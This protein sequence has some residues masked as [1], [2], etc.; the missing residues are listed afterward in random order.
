MGDRVV[1]RRALPGE[2]RIVEEAVVVLERGLA[3][4][5]RVDP[6]EVGRVEVVLDRE[7][8]VPAHLEADLAVGGGRA[9]APLVPRP[10]QPREALR[11]RSDPGLEGRRLPGEVDEHEV[12][13][14]RAPHLP[15]PVRGAVEALRLVHP[16]AAEVRG[17]DETPPKVVGP[18]VVG[19]PD[20]PRPPS[21]LPDQLGAAMRAHVVEHAHRP[22]RRADHEERQA[23]EPG[24]AEVARPRDVR[25]VSEAGPR[26]GEDAF[27]LDPEE[28]E[29]RI[30]AV[31]EPGRLPDGP[32]D[33]GREGR[34][35][36]V[37]AHRRL[38]DEPTGRR[39]RAGDG[40]RSCTGSEMPLLSR[41]PSGS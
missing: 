39:R 38:V 21:G 20:G 11:E 16:E 29:A 14:D 28:V 19:A 34:D 10:A 30:G 41:R 26:G 35:R 1:G 15:E 31:G 3:V 8:P 17:P 25:R 2:P 33:S 22:A 27:A 5:G 18:G 13:P 4:E 7:L 23:E 37:R 32:F 36:E 40:M 6:R 12:Q 9:Q 24:R